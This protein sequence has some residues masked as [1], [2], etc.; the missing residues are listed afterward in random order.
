VNVCREEKRTNIRAAGADRSIILK[1]PRQ[2]TL[3]Q[4]LE[5]IEGDELVAVTPKAIPLRKIYLK[6][7]DRRKQARQASS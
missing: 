3:E 6:G 4:A 5:Y 7:S 1:P 2:L